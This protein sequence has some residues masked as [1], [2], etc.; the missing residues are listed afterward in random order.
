MKQLYLHSDYKFL[1]KEVLEFIENFDSRGEY[2]VKGERNSIKKETLQNETLNVKQ[3]KIPNFFNAFI[4]KYIRKSKARRSFEYASILI[5]KGILTPFP[6]AYYEE[7]TAFGLR[8]SYY[9]SQQVEYDLDFRVLIHDL[10]YPNRDE[11]LRQFTAFTFKLHE[12]NIN[13]LD[14]SPG[15]TLIV[16]NEDGNYDFYLIDLNRMRFE[17]MDFNKR[18]HNIRRLWPSKAMIKI[19][20]KTYSKLYNKSYESTHALML[21]HARDFQRK[22]DS[23]KLR[24][25]G[26]KIKFKS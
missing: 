22:I 18:M 8:N 14:H 10:N 12:N 4:Y 23:K 6:I 5:E 21:I 1:E 16:D 15:N 20:A 25:S 19:M 13:F 2:V 9:V 7:T 11:I 17:P 3:Y 24:R 26:R